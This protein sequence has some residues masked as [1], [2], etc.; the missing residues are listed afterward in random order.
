[1][2]A[3]KAFRSHVPKGNHGGSGGDPHPRCMTVQK[4][5][6]VVTWLSQRL[7]QN[8]FQNHKWV[9]LSRSLTDYNW[10]P[11]IKLQSPT[12]PGSHQATRL[13]LT[14]PLDPSRPESPCWTG[15]LQ[16]STIPFPLR[17]FQRVLGLQKGL[18]VIASVC[19][20]INTTH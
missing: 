11:P 16:V 17:A 12:D 13:L 14:Q 20:G 3:G 8:S 18:G 4:A 2:K 1:M 7:P 6:V 5:Q 19:P 10:P 9:L 15:A